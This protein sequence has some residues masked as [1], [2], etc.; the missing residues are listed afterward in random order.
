MSD[1]ASG[2]R[3]G[4]PSTTQP[5]AGPWLSP[6]VVTRNRWPKLLWLTGSGGRRDDIEPALDAELQPMRRLRERR[7]IVVQQGE[8]D[9]ERGEA[10]LDARRHPRP[11]DRASRPADRSRPARLRD[12]DV[13]R[14][15]VLHANDMVAAVDMVNLAGHA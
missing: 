11:R 1:S 5:I 13:R 6:Q 7:K 4:Q 15:R 14:R 8:P 2:M 9:R 3:G 10:R 12:G